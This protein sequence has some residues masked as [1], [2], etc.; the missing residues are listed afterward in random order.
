MF[1]RTFATLT[2][3]LMA[4]LAAAGGLD[5]S[6]DYL[7]G[8]PAWCHSQTEYD[9]TWSEGWSSSSY[10]S[11][12]RCDDSF[13][14]AAANASDD[15]G[16]VAALRAGTTQRHDRQDEGSESA[17]SWYGND[18]SSHS[19]QRSGAWS[20]RSAQQRE[21]ELATR[22]G[23]VRATDGCRA[24][25]RGTSYRSDSTTY[26]SG[27]ASG[28][29]QSYASGER[30]ADE[31]CGTRVRAERGG[32]RYEVAPR[33]DR[34]R[35][36]DAGSGSAYG[37]YADNASGGGS[38]SSWAYRSDCA[39]GV[40]ADADG[41]A[42]RAG[43]VSRC[44]GGSYHQSWNDQGG[45]GGHSAW[46][47]Q[48]TQGYEVRGPDGITLLLAQDTADGESCERTS[49]GETCAQHGVAVRYVVLTWGHSPLGPSGVGMP[50][51]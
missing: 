8:E 34:C 12:E 9:G 50:L 22:E 32:D 15:E 5:A 28:W 44:H 38:S 33:S 10:A 13:T 30:R 31:E 45:S 1:P 46:S 7:E 39:H 37:W 4:P 40:E 36:E 25:E 14:Y 27:Y 23:S 20:N 47:S 29:R 35:Q 11:R 19:S 21:A 6:V 48:C 2:L 16:S 26:G 24:E 43:S 3:L 18:S 17:Y 51:P 49:D 42:V 41:T